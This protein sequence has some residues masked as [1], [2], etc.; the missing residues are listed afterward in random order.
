[1]SC[2]VVYQ[3]FSSHPHY[4]ETK[5]TAIRCNT[6]NEDNSKIEDNKRALQ[7]LDLGQQLRSTPRVHILGNSSNSYDTDF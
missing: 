5:A 3:M 7:G 4:Q 2:N 1:M 6:S